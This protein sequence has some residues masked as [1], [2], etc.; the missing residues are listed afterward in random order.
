MAQ[1]MEEL[2]IQVLFLQEVDLRH[3]SEGMLVFP[4]Y[5]V[6][7]HGGQKKRSVTV[8]KHGTFKR[9]AQLGEENTSPQV[10]LEAETDMGSITLGNIYREWNGNQD[11]DMETLCQWAE[12]RKGSGGVILAGDFNLDPSRTGDQTY[13]M[14]QKTTRFLARMSGAG[15]DRVAFGKTFKRQVAGR[16][17]S[18]ELDWVLTS[19][20]DAVVKPR[21][22][23]SGLSDH[24]L[25]SWEVDSLQF[26]SKKLEEKCWGRKLNQI[27]LNKFKMDLVFAPW[28]ELAEIDSM[29]ELRDKFHDLFLTVLDKHAPLQEIKSRTKV[30]KKPSAALRKLRRQR[31]NARS[32]GKS[33]LLRDLRKKCEQLAKEECIQEVQA[34][35]DRDPTAVWKIV[36]EA[37]GKVHNPQPSIKE[38]GKILT[39][40][41][42]AT[43]FNHY[44]PGKIRN[45]QER[46]PEFKGDPLYGAKR[47]AERLGVKKGEFKLLPVK[48]KA[49]VSAIKKT[50][51]SRC[52][53]IYGIAPAVIKMAPEILAVPLTWIVNRSIV[54]GKVPSGWKRGRVLPLHKKKEK[55]KKENYRPVCILPSFGKVMEEI[56]RGQMSSF[57]EERG[58]LPK[59]QYGFRKNRSTLLAGAVAEH[60]LKAAKQRKLK[61][62][63]LFF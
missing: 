47:R 35:L 15:L 32:K 9:I 57:L 52:P 26:T 28:E 42:A 53:D 29:D 11:E 16:V 55:E 37:T 19:N 14:S 10:W 30:T 49:I 34:R 45:I 46:I 20:R 4:G 3:F 1:V 41:E 7:V 36:K 43:T 21:T 12:E 5:E 40:G 6:F 27:D 51:S 38:E 24:D 17:I 60:E 18:S 56:V 8:V 54:E 50:K 13:A 44:F 63:A 23:P 62:G 31:D 22:I 33:A 48:E 58:I 25:I 61:C 59:S 39:Q 2:G